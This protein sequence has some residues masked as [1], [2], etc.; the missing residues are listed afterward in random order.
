MAPNS[1]VEGYWGL[2][3]GTAGGSRVLISVMSLTTRSIA[4]VGIAAIRLGRLVSC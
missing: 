1:Q 4:V 2:A 3:R